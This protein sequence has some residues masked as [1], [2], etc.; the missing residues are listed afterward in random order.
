MKWYM[1]LQDCIKYIEENLKGEIDFD[2]LSSLSF[3]SK[4]YFFRMFEAVTGISV[5]E[6]IRNRRMTLAAKELAS[7]AC[8]VIDIAL[9]FGYSSPEA[10]S[11]AFKSVHGIPPS[12]VTTAQSGML[13]S[14]SP[15]S[16][17][18]TVKGDKELNYKI[19]K[20][21]AFKVIGEVLTTTSEKEQNFK[22]LPRFW[23]RLHSDGT[24]TKML[25]LS[26]DSGTSFGVCFPV[27]EGSQEFNYAIAVPYSGKDDEQFEIFDIPEATWVVFEFT[28]PMP[29]A[30]QDGLN[31]IFSEWLPATEYEID[32][33]M[34]DIELYYPGSV[35]NPDYKSEI[36]IAIK[37]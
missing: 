21:K 29:S 4:R 36:W 27:V 24:F 2:E 9:E 22:E 16:F 23:D 11:R 12:S 20:K 15:L 31:M 28:G 14:F 17:K 26:D 30:I 35:Q 33:T 8:K 3:L 25:G 7:E 19:E 32:N 13:K 10:F 34:P 6:Y 37:T 1:R 18:I 5:I